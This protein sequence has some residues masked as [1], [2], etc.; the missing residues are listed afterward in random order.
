LT[1]GSAV[2]K[3]PQK[4]LEERET[5][6]EQTRR[7]KVEIRLKSGRRVKYTIRGW[8]WFCYRHVRRTGKKKAK[9]REDRAVGYYSAISF[10]I[11]ATKVGEGGMG[12]RWQ[13]RGEW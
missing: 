4:E 1:P 7:N 6:Y 8:A 10:L 12:G 9:K 2:I 13:L 11:T 5:W 3:I